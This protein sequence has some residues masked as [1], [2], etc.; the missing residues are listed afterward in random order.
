MNKLGA[1]NSPFVELE[2][3]WVDDGIPS[4]ADEVLNARPFGA[5]TDSYNLLH[6]KAGFELSLAGNVVSIDLSVRNLLDEDYTDFLNPYKGLP[7]MGEPVLNPGR[8]VRL[9][10]RYRF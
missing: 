5:A 7:Y 1:L 8:D 10:A 9:L 2:S 3:V 6:V 4:G